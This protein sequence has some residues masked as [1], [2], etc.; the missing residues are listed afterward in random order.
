MFGWV[1]DRHFLPFV[2]YLAV[3][4]GIVGHTGGCAACLPA[5]PARLGWPEGCRCREGNCP[6]VLSS[7]HV[8][9]CPSYPP[10]DKCALTLALHR[11]AGFNTLLRYL[12]PLIISLACNMEPLI[13]S[14]LGWGAGVVSAPGA[15]TYVGGGLV[16]AS[17]L[18]VSLA[19]HRREQ[20]AASRQKAAAKVRRIL[21]GSGA[22]GD[23]LA[24]GQDTPLMQP[25][26]GAEVANGFGGAHSRSGRVGASG[27]SAEE[28][29]EDGGWGGLWLQLQDEDRDASR[30]VQELRLLS[31]PS[32]V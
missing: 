25:G 17:T 31:P 4:P 8:V 13:G 27:P 14:L 23:G 16:M 28:L 12:D 24:W 19:S 20:Q 2:L 6:F 3:V 7:L 29:A 15:W 22:S 5:C 26:L 10:A 32:G 18:V 21:G 11:F 9:G 30:G 1:A